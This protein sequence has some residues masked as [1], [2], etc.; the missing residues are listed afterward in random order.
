LKRPELQEPIA[1]GLV[2]GSA[3]R[4]LARSLG[5]APSTVTRQS[6]RLGRH[7]F[8]FMSR[9]I[10]NLPRSRLEPIAAD[11]YE[12]F[13]FTQDHPFGVLTLV[14]R[15]SWFVYLLDPVPHRRSGCIS[16]AQRERLKTRPQ[17]PRRGGYRGSFKRGL[18]AMLDLARNREIVHVA[19]DGK[20]TY[21]EAVQAHRETDRILLSCY[22]NPRRAPKGSPRSAKGRRRD[23]ALHTVDQFHELIRHTL[24]CEK[25]ETIAFGRRLNAIVERLA[26]MMVWRNFVKGRSERQ[27]D[28]ST[29][30]MHVGLT[31]R[32][33]AWAEVLARRR[34][35]L[36]ER[37][38][39]VWHELY[40]RAWTTPLLQ[41]N[42]RHD[43]RHAF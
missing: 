19:C 28:H 35:F 22:P 12:S 43:L 21:R 27:P 37:V 9:A 34:F 29:P 40:R 1:K 14:G 16:P 6:A 42:T 2:A 32:P 3:H 39:P 20:S 31:R 36:R 38:P 24:A 18:D 4:Q 13:E 15:E 8:L 25:R 17:R 7:A 10:S 26:L 11:H 23:A 41:S 5:C 30:A 33:W